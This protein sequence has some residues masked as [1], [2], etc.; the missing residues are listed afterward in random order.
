MT[1][2]KNYPHPQP[3]LIDISNTTLYSTEQLEQ[4]RISNPDLQI[5]LT[6]DGKL[7]VISPT[8]DERVEAATEEKEVLPPANSQIADS[9]SSGKYQLPELTPEETA[10]RVA[11]IERHQARRQ[12][13]MDSLTPEELAASNQQFADMFKML[14]ESRR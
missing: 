11:M 6:E 7:I 5:E 2:A 13:I 12:E 1:I 14:E 3:L 8:I 9:I 4:L 10:R